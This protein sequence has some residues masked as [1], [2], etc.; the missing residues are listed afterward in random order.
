MSPKQ[1][2]SAFNVFRRI[3]DEVQRAGILYP[4]P[5]TH[6]REIAFHID[7]AI[8]HFEGYRAGD[9]ATP[10][11]SRGRTVMVTL[12]QSVRTRLESNRAQGRPPHVFGY[13]AH[14]IAEAAGRKVSSVHAQ[15]SRMAFDASSLSDVVDYICAARVSENRLAGAVLAAVEQGAK[16]VVQVA[17]AARLA[18]RHDLVR[19]TL[20]RLEEAGK[21]VKSRTTA[22]WT[23]AN[24]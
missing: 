15:I 5:L 23:P 19:D 13:T 8:A 6:I 21:V 2:R 24:K 9:G 11:R 22:S 10:M 14:D 18:D 12:P 3:E 20:D 4:F 1:I 7:A 16:T 17:E